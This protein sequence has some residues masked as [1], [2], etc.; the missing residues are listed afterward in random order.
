MAKGGEFIFGK[1]LKHQHAVDGR[2]AA[3]GR[4]RVFGQQF[5][6]FLGVKA[7][8]AVNE[9]GGSTEPGP[10]IAAPG[11]F[12]PTGIAD[13]PMH[14]FGLE[15]Q[16]E[17][18]GDLMPQWIGC[19]GVKSHFG[20]PDGAGCKI[21]DGFFVFGSLGCFKNIGSS[22]YDFCII[23]PSI[24]AAADNQFAFQGR[25]FV[26]DFLKL[27][28]ITVIRNE[29]NGFGGIDPIFEI[30]GGQLGGSGSDDD[31]HADTGREDFPPFNG[32]PQNDH[33]DIT[34]F[35]TILSQ[36]IAES[37]GCLAEIQKCSFG[38]KTIIIDPIHSQFIRILRPFIDDIACEIKILRHFPF[39]FCKSLVVIRHVV[40]HSS[41][42]YVVFSITIS[43][44]V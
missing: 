16:P 27:G 5:E 8:R 14:V 33:H 15:I 13:V 1:R 24:S 11:G 30:F 39:K 10:K 37:L 28:C 25:T 36:Y 43:L 19:M 32:T 3:H 20:E 23:Q 38:L 41:P 7:V 35:D 12:G 18:S 17:S 4:N 29:T 34:P 26:G 44:P 2:C 42:L 31:A 22:I 21:N 40:S 9:L 6:C